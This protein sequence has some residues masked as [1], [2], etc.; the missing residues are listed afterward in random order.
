MGTVTGSVGDPDLYGVEAVSEISL[1]NETDRAFRDG[2]LRCDV[3]SIQSQVDRCGIDTRLAIREAGR[4]HGTGIVGEC[5]VLGDQIGDPRWGNIQSLGATQIVRGRVRPWRQR[6][7]R[8]RGTPSR[9]KIQ[10]EGH[11]VGDVDVTII[12]G[13]RCIQAGR[14]LPILEQEIQK[15]NGI[16]DIHLAI[17]VGI[18][19]EEEG[20]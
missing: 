8:R 17:A 19:P 20:T 1:G 16:G 4:D 2:R 15:P 6:P 5:L 10:K 9:V 3:F 18:A 14:R 11:R 13:V 12:V 7:R